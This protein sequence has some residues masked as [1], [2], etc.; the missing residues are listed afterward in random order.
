MQDLASQPA[1]NVYA[2]CT[3]VLCLNLLVLWAYSGVV[4]GKSK[5]TP[6]H[7]DASTVAKGADLSE[8][9]TPEEAR[10]L[11]AHTN[12]LANIVPFLAVGLLYAL[13]GAPP[14]MAW[15]FFGGFTVARLGHTFAYLG[16]KQPWRTLCF[17][18]GVLFTLGV[19]VQIARIAIARMM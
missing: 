2:L 8:E 3:I 10:V 9:K 5:R 15:I 11:R 7:E 6:N 17:A 14:T 1:F 12:A 18:L 19:M 13:Y 4:R 16:G